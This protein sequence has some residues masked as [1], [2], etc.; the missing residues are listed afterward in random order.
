MSEIIIS[1]KEV[2]NLD[3][4]HLRAMSRNSN[5]WQEPGISE[6]Q[7]YAYLSTK[8]NDSIILDIG[9]RY[10]GSALALSFNESNHVRSYDIEEQ[11]ASYIQ[12]IM[13]LGI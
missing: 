12:K 3:I 13:S 1:K 10:G 4:T 11:G 2:I 6:Y 9:T 5:D 7:L 8:F